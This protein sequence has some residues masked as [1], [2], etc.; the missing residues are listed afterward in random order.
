MIYI[1][2]SPEE[3]DAEL[4]S[5][6]KQYGAPVFITT[7]NSSNCFFSSSS[8]TIS[9]KLYVRFKLADAIRAHGHLTA[10]IYPLNDGPKDDSKIDVRHMV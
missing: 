6:F 9:I 5:L 10:D 4:A 2:Q 3:V 1:L 7:T 8:Q